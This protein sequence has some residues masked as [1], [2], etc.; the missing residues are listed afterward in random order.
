VQRVVAASAPQPVRHAVQ[1]GLLLDGQDLQS[2]HAADPEVQEWVSSLWVE[3]LVGG[4]PRRAD[5]P[6]VIVV[7]TELSL[8]TGYRLCRLAGL[9]KVAW[10][11]GEPMDADLTQP[12]LGRAHAES[13]HDRLEPAGADFRDLVLH[14]VQSNPTSKWPRRRHAARLGL[15]TIARLLADCEPFRIRWA[16][17]HWPYTIAKLTRSLMPPVSQ[18][19]RMVSQGEA[20]VLKTAWDRLNLEGR[21][22]QHGPDSNRRPWGAI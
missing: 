17:Q 16:L 3:R 22:P 15:L 6:P 7:L 12:F 1:A 13:L 5:D 19:S 11:Q 18:R 20:L 14:D 4:E 9:A 21:L 8:R 10:A 2:D